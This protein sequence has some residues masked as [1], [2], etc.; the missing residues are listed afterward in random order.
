[1]RLL[2]D[3]KEEIKLFSPTIHQDDRGF[4]VEKFNQY[5]S[6][7]LDYNFNFIQ[8]NESFSS[9]AGTVRGIH[10]QKPPFEQTKILSV[11]KGSIMD[12]AID[13]RPESSDFGKKYTY[14]LDDKDRKIIVIPK[15]YGHAFCTL[16]D[17]TLITYKVDCKYSMPEEVSIKWDDEDININ[18]PHFENYHLSEKD[19]N[20]P[21]LRE[22]FPGAFL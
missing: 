1:M 14:I 12:V 19:R 10:Y 8:E 4:F 13:L 21:S 2:S 18:W 6:N 3:P 20:A 17:N 9:H 5:L 11:H 7:E 16:E 22:V 15:G